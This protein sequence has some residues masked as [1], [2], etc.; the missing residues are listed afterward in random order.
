VS[1][2]NF[3]RQAMSDGAVTADAHR[4]SIAANALNDPDSA[5]ARRARRGLTMTDPA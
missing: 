1:P 2:H 5:H 4:R 3:L